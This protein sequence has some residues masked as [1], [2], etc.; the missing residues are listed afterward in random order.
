[1]KFISVAVQTAGRCFATGVVA[2]SDRRPFT[3]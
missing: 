3:T 2:V 1:M